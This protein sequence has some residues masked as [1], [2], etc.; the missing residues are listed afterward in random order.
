MKSVKAYYN[1]KRAVILSYKKQSFSVNIKHDLHHSVD[2]LKKIPQEAQSRFV[3]LANLGLS[4]FQI[5][6]TGQH[7]HGHYIIYSD[8]Y[9]KCMEYMK[10]EIYRDENPRSSALK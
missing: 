6:N 3:S 10:S 7:E 4:L 2:T 9:I 5:R 8:V 1:C